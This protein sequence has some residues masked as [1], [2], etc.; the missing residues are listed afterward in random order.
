MSGSPSLSSFGSFRFDVS[1]PSQSGGT[2]PLEHGFVPLSI[3]SA[4]S[5]P[6]PSS[7]IDALSAPV[8]P[9]PP[10]PKSFGSKT[11][12]VP[13]VSATQIV[14][15]NAPVGPCVVMSSGWPPTDENSVVFETTPVPVLFSFTRY[16]VFLL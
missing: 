15:G 8:Q 16:T 12:I 1:S 4:L 11:W 5:K 9:P 7:S 6:S 10:P 3:S 14:P 13:F 2:S